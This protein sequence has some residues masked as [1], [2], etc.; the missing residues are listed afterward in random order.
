MGEN[1]CD[2]SILLHMWQWLMTDCS[3]EPVF[4]SRFLL[5]DSFVSENERRRQ[6]HMHPN[7]SDSVPDLVR[8]PREQLHHLR[9]RLQTTDETPKWGETG[10]EAGFEVI[11]PSQQPSDVPTATGKINVRIPV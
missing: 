3:S 8:T 10:L 5:F 1:R 7:Y 11:R 2:S 4:I 9:G 6:P